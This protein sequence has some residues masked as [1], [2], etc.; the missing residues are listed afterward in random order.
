MRVNHTRTV[1]ILSN[2]TDNDFKNQ[3]YPGDTS[4][5]KLQNWPS[6][7]T[8]GAFVSSTYALKAGNGTAQ[9]CAWTAQS[10]ATGTVPDMFYSVRTGDAQQHIVRIGGND[11]G[12]GME[13]SNNITLTGARNSNIISERF[14]VLPSE[15]NGYDD[16]HIMSAAQTSGNWEQGSSSSNAS[17]SWGWLWQYASA[18]NGTRQVRSGIA[19]DHKGSEEFKYWSSYGDHTWYVDSAASGDE[20]AE[21]CSTKAMQICRKGS[22][23]NT[24]NPTYGI[25][26]HS[27]VQTSNGGIKNVQYLEDCYGQWIVV[28][29]IQQSSHLQSAMASV[30][31][32]DTSLGQATGT[33]WSA[34]FGGVYPI[35]VRYVSSSNWKNWRDNRGVDFIQGVPHG[36]KWKN[37][38]SN[39]AS[40]GMT[41]ATGGVGSTKYGWTCDG[42]WDGKG[43]WHNPN[44]NWWRMSDP[45]TG[46]SADF[47]NQSFFTSATAANASTALNLN[48]ANDAKFG[49]HATAATGGQDTE[50]TSV[51]GYD[52]NVYGHEDNYP[53]SPAN[54]SGSDIT[55]MPL[56]ICLNV[57][58]IGQFH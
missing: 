19:Y 53:S 52:D 9:V 38:F 4:G 45:G 16:S 50:V 24:A 6:S 23:I 18:N 13:I 25:Y 41:S 40:S 46:F 10:T 57:T 56:W 49:V 42:A 30:A 3:N 39:G 15:N 44:F 5:I 14:R 55:A 35:A 29:K 1:R 54:N 26:T 17:S 22:V 43:R 58:G 34:S 12:R 20:T 27:S 2:S 32:I 47:C 36:R 21:T 37:F 8:T 11:I 33:E 51:Y 28:A 31:Q 48:W 7:N